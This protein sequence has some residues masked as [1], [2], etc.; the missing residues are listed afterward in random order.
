M[1]QIFISLKKTAGILKCF[2]YANIFH[3]INSGHIILEG[4]R[5]VIYKEEIR[6]KTGS[7]ISQDKHYPK[8]MVTIR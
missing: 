7:A 3:H 4:I 6:V 2:G 5:N 1:N 8:P